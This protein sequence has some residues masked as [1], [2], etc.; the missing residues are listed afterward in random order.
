MACA[1]NGPKIWELRGEYSGLYGVSVEKIN[2]VE[3]GGRTEK[4]TEGQRARERI[5][6]KITKHRCLFFCLFFFRLASFIIIIYL[7]YFTILYW[8]CHTLTWIC[9]RCIYVPHPETP[10]DLPPHPIPLG[11]PSAPAPSTL[12]HAS[13]LDWQ[14]VSHMI[15][16][17]FQCHFPISVHRVQKTVLYICVFFAVSHTGLSLLS[18]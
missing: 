9:H 12:S 13:N 6:S 1:L 7:L 16:Y 15:I 3:K 5:F 4:K 10:S 14:F 17:M 8:F 11:H 2:E 18:F